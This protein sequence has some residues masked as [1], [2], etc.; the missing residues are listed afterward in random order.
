[1]PLGMQ[2]VLVLVACGSSDLP[3]LLPTTDAE[4]PPPS[5]VKEEDDD[6]LAD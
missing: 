2:A 3:P 5:P 4:A 1:M 6:D